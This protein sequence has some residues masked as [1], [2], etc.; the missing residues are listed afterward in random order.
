MTT[1]DLAALRAMYLNL[2]S[3]WAAV[4]DFLGLAGDS[5]APE[6]IAALSRPAPAPSL[7]VEQ[8]DLVSLMDRIPAMHGR[9]VPPTGPYVLLADIYAAFGADKAVARL[10]AEEPQP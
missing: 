5:T 10:S 3:D 6:V 1:D 4:T 2:V 9:L 7:D 8:L